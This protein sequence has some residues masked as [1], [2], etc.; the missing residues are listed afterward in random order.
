MNFKKEN[1]FSDAFNI[2]FCLFYSVTFPVPYRLHLKILQSKKVL[3]KIHLPIYCIYN[4]Y[5]EL[6]IISKFQA[7]YLSHG[8][9]Q[10]ILAKNDHDLESKCNVL[11]VVF[12]IIFF[13]FCFFVF[14]IFK[15][16]LMSYKTGELSYIVKRVKTLNYI[17]YFLGT[18]L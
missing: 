13:Y 5:F 12:F 2:A 14:F 1:L 16:N 18:F 6:F 11:L 4:D 3:I 9:Y 7:R 15:F 8:F 17:K 10:V